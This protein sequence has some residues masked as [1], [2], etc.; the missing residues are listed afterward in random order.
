MVRSQESK[1]GEV[2][3]PCDYER[4]ESCGDRKYKGHEVSGESG[5]T[6]V[7]ATTEPNTR[8]QKKKDCQLSSVWGPPS[9]HS[10]ESH[11]SKQSSLTMVL[12]TCRKFW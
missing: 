10:D 11:D 2:W 1:T 4:R 6:M 3:C 5:H 12:S 7:S 9:I 8:T